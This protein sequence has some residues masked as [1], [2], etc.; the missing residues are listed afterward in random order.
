MQFLKTLHNRGELFKQATHSFVHLS[1]RYATLVWNWNICLRA[2]IMYCKSSTCSLYKLRTDLRLCKICH[3]ACNMCIYMYLCIPVFIHVFRSCKLIS[4]VI[5]LATSHSHHIQ[6]FGVQRTGYAR[7]LP[8]TTTTVQRSGRMWSTCSG[9]HIVYM[10][11]AERKVICLLPPLD[12]E[13]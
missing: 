7:I 12:Y 1:Q 8:T 9:A 2:Y 6:S 5:T 13:L 3:Y 11:W 10:S 4:F